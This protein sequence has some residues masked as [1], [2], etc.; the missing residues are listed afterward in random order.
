MY[1]NILYFSTFHFLSFS[2]TRLTFDTKI[3]TLSGE[4][5]ISF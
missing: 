1:I 5:E 2:L 3:Q 4:T